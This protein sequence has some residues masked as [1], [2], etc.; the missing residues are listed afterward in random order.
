MFESFRRYLALAAQ[1][2][3]V[4]AFWF[5]TYV[6]CRAKVRDNLQ[7]PSHPGA[8]FVV[9]ANH[10]SRLDPFVIT[11]ALGLRHARRLWT[12]RYI[13]GNAYLY[14]PKFAWLLWP[15]G[16]FPAYPTKR[17]GYGLEQAKKILNS[18]QT[19]CIFPEGR[20]SKPHEFE[21]KRGVSVLADMPKTY[22]IPIHLQWRLKPRG[23]TVTIGNAYNA[24]SQSPDSILKTIYDLAK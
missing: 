4:P 6:V 14:S 18:G 19:V 20:R 24:A 1:I 2:L 5:M 21:A 16:G 3:W 11:G 7:A 9:A 12:Y 17:E 8:H 23:V 13:T 22:V 10:Q 15:L